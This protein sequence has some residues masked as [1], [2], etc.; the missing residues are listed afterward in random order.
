MMDYEATHNGTGRNI[1]FSALRQPVEVIGP[2]V[3]IRDLQGAY[4]VGDYVDYKVRIT[5]EDEAHSTVKQVDVLQ[6]LTKRDGGL[7]RNSTCNR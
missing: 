3:E 1:Y 4:K 6:K 2:T 5:Y 7:L